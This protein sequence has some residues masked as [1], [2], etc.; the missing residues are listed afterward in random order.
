MA[1]GERILCWGMKGKGGF[2]EEALSEGTAVTVERINEWG[3]VRCMFLESGIYCRKNEATGYPRCRY[4]LR[5]HG[6]EW[7]ANGRWV[8]EVPDAEKLVDRVDM[9]SYGFVVDPD[10]KRTPAMEYV[11]DRR[12][13]VFLKNVPITGLAG[14][15]EE[16]SASREFA[17]GSP[18][19]EEE[20]E[21]FFG[22]MINDSEM[23]VYILREDE[24][25]E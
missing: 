12:I 5:A 13:W 15:A 2:E 9:V 20:G 16:L 10:R 6:V 18:V 8:K 1:G 7:M 14:E 25:G 3:E 11:G 4:Y 21:V 23:G 24:S 19:Y 22:R 17:L